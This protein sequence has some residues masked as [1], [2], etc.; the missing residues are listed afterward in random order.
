MK[1][2]SRIDFNFIEEKLLAV[3]MHD[4]AEALK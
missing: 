3:L 2:E 1:V 4:V